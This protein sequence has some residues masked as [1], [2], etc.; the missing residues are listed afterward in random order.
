MV[1]VFAVC[2]DEKESRE[3]LL[4]YA[5]RLA[6]RQGIIVRLEAFSSAEEL[7]VGERDFD[8][9]LLDVELGEMDGISA[10]GR[11]RKEGCQ[12]VIILVT[13]YVQYAIDGY[14]VQA[15]HFL[16][17]PVEYT[18]FCQVA[19]KAV[20]LTDQKKRQ[21]ISVKGD[22]EVIRILA[23]DIWY[24]ETDRGRILIHT[25]G[26]VRRCYSSM[27]QLEKKLT[28]CQF[29]RCH[30]AYLVNLAEISRLLPAEIQMK[31]GSLLPVSK[32]RKK[33]FRETLAKYW[34]GIFL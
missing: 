32:H 34:G 27:A 5:Q 20:R 7:L 25:A 17:K 11:L 23:A 26:G 9:L 15:F 18:R 16:H 10:A 1:V 6:K 14:E 28:P 24:C 4:E 19:G 13:N 29:F 22:N 21:A 12:A 30:T 31:D 33:E 3:L 2:D 8:I